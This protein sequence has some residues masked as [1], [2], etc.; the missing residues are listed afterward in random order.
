[1]R[2]VA[3][4]I[5][6]P[7]FRIEFTVG[8]DAANGVA[9]LDVSRGADGRVVPGVAND[10]VAALQGRVG[11]EQGEPVGQRR[12]AVGAGLAALPPGVVEPVLQLVETQPTVFEGDGGRSPQ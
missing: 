5:N 1:M 7:D 9:R 3:H 4:S 11:V 8:E 12:E 6:A 10:G 2:L